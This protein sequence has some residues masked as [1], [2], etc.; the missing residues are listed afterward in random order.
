[1]KE[2]SAYIV[3]YN[4]HSK[5]ILCLAKYLRVIYVFIFKDVLQLYMTYKKILL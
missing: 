4:D 2:M 1:M 3:I 5:V